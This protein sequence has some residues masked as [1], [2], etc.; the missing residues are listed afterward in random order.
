MQAE[1][2]TSRPAKTRARRRRGSARAG[3]PARPPRAARRPASRSRSASRSSQ[4]GKRRPSPRRNAASALRV[5]RGRPRAPGRA[6]RT[7]R[8]ARHG[9]PS[10]STPWPA[11]SNQKSCRVPAEVTAPPGELGD[12]LAPGAERFG[13]RFSDRFQKSRYAVAGGKE[14]EDEAEPG[15]AERPGRPRPL[16]PAREAP[17]GRSTRGSWRTALFMRPGDRPGAGTGAARGRLVADHHRAFTKERG[18]GLSPSSGRVEPSCA[19]RAVTFSPR[20]R[21]RAP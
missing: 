10:A 6:P 21:R 5:E 1:S 12:R 20:E 9:S 16:D 19:R 18:S 15:R 3:T 8:R 7:A 11:R 13:E 4:D 14:G 17:G 2:S